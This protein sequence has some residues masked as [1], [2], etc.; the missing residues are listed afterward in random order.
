MADNTCSDLK[1]W[2]AGTYHGVRRQPLRADVDEFVFGYDRRRHRDAGFYRLP[3]IVD[4]MPP[5]IHQTMTYRN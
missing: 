1:R 3:G 4:N 5:A 2:A